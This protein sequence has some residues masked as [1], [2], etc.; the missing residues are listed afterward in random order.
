MTANPSLTDGKQQV[1]YLSGVT[2]SAV[3]F[4]LFVYFS[5]CKIEY[6]ITGRCGMDWINNWICSTLIICN[7]K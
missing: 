4:K 7:Y 6:L 5:K 1:E 2:R 3:K